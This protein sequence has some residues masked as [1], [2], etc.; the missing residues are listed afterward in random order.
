MTI[1]R[2]STEPSVTVAPSSSADLADKVL[3]MVDD[4]CLAEAM[5]LPARQAYLRSYS[6]AANLRCLKDA[7]RAAI[8]R[9]A[10]RAGAGF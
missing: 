10:R 4:P 5:R 3:R 7:Y 8:E 6:E 9:R 1:A 2:S